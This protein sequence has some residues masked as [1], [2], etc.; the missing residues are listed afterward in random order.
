MPFRSSLLAPA[1]EHHWPAAGGWIHYSLRD[2][3]VAEEVCYWGEMTF[4]THVLNLLTKRRVEAH[5]SFGAPLTGVADRK[6]LAVAL[7]SQVRGLMEAHLS[8]GAAEH[9][10]A[11]N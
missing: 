10:T 1:V 9:G 8:A 5:V 2:G 7:H 3:V 11:R 4:G 6:E